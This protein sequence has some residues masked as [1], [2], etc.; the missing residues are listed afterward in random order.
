MQPD[1][2]PCEILGQSIVV[3]KCNPLFILEYKHGMEASLAAFLLM[4]G[5][6]FRVGPDEYIVVW[7]DFMLSFTPLK[8]N[9]NKPFI[10][11]EYMDEET[12]DNGKWITTRRLNGDEGT[13]AAI[14]YLVSVRIKP[15]AYGFRDSPM[16]YT[17]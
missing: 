12:Y 13:A 8:A 14:M 11:M 10:D 5:L 6:I 15:E 16:M 3:L 4:A 9:R 1:I 2:N 7:K 17:A